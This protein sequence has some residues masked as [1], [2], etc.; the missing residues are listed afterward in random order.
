[1]LQFITDSELKCAPTK[2]CKRHCC[3]LAMLNVYI[4]WEVGFLIYYQAGNN[5][6]LKCMT[7]S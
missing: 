1:M 5:E 2:K 6:F 7:I 4:C 3:S